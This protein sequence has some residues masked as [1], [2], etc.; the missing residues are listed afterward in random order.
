M[1]KSLRRLG[2]QYGVTILNFTKWRIF[3]SDHHNISDVLV[4]SSHG[5]SLRYDQG[6]QDLRRPFNTTL[7]FPVREGEVNYYKPLEDLVDQRYEREFEKVGMG[8]SLDDC[9][10][11]KFQGK[12]GGGNV[13]NYRTICQGMTSG[14]SNT[15]YDVLTVRHR[16]LRSKEVG[17]GQILD[18]LQ[19]MGWRYR[20]IV[21]QFCRVYTVGYVH[22]V[23]NR[24]Y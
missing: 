21:C 15:I 3:R 22:T 20:E 8:S 13:A 5:A 17:L 24:P 12:H 4:I 16:N 11:T 2:R 18:F 14:K 23:T 19:G 9:G 7:F 6:G 10:L 1:A